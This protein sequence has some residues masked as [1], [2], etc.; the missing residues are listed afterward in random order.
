MRLAQATLAEVEARLRGGEAQAHVGPLAVGRR[1]RGRAV[2]RRAAPHPRRRPAGLRRHARRPRGVRR[3]R[4]IGT[5]CAS[6]WRTRSDP[7]DRSSD[8]YRVVRPD[9]S[10]RRIYLR[11][12]PT[13]SSAGLVVGL[14]GIGQD[15]TDDP[16]TRDRPAT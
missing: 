7:A 9:G 10:E 15:L 8:E 13:L 2:E 5:A 16:I 1:H 14:R 6:R 11:A 3:I 4:T 12:E